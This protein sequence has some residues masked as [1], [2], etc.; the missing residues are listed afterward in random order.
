MKRIK[1]GKH[2]GDHVGG[3]N[4]L[5]SAMDVRERF[6]P[7]VK[8]VGHTQEK[9]LARKNSEKK[10]KKIDRE[11]LSREL[12]QIKCSCFVVQHTRGGNR[13]RKTGNRQDRPLRPTPA[14]G[15][16]LPHPYGLEEEG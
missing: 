14:Q 15:S 7:A 10:N 13:L 9:K 11:E 8:H 4:C 5:G 2:V 12:H 16:K 3:A 6:L 1:N